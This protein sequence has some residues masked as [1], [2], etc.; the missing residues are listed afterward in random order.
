MGSLQ[1]LLLP[2]AD[3]TSSEVNH[4]GST[5]AR[6]SELSHE[7]GTGVAYS[8]TGLAVN[9]ARSR[10]QIS[11]ASLTAFILMEYWARFLHCMIIV[12]PN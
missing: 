5:E 10:K 6:P 3:T 7:E 11:L 12:Y 2:V 4:I 9:F 8:K 1:K